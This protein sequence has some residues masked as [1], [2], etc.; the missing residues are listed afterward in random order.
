MQDFT[1]Y[2]LILVLILSAALAAHSY[3]AS[4]SHILISVLAFATLGVA[5]L[6]AM[7]ITV[8]NYALKHHP[9]HSVPLLRVLPPVQTMQNNLFK[10]I[11]TGFIFLSLSFLGAFI[12]LPNVLQAIP[13]SKLVLSSLAWVL[14]AT[15]LYGYHRSGWRQDIVTARTLGGV[16]LLII[17]YFGSKGIKLN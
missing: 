9:L 15:L 7:I 16:F 2:T 6:Q 11:W 13:L 3:A 17:A 14:F 5:A 12:Y 4:I 10:I 1:R 8:Q